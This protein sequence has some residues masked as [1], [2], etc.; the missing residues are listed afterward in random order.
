MERDI[1]QDLALDTRVMVLVMDCIETQWLKETD[2][3]THIF[4]L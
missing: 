3:E 4:L 2:M 1:K